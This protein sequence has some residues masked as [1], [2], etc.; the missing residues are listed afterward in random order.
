MGS[1]ILAEIL[2]GVYVLVTLLQEDV[3]AG[4]EYKPE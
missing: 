2:V 4:F 3:K 1:F